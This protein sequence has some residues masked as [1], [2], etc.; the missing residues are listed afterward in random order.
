MSVRGRMPPRMAAVASYA[1]LG[2]STLD[3]GSGLTLQ[4]SGGVTAG[5]PASHP[6][7]FRGRFESF[8]GCRGVYARLDLLEWSGARQ[9]VEADAVTVEP[10]QAWVRS[11]DSRYQVRLEGGTPRSRTCPWWAKHR[12]AWVCCAMRRCTVDGS[13]GVIVGRT[14]PPR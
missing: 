11:G 12:G 1:Y 13:S 3:A 5:G 6:C 7:F 8:S 9:L 14:C 10:G 4:T 2:S